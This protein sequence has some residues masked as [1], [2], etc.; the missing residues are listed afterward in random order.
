MCK[1]GMLAVH[2]VGII[3]PD[4]FSYLDGVPDAWEHEIPGMR[5]NSQN[6]SS[7]SFGEAFN[8]SRGSAASRDE[9]FY[10]VLGGA[11][12][13]GTVTRSK[14][15]QALPSSSYRAGTIP[16]AAEEDK[17]WSHNSQNWNK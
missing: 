3:H 10:C 12:R 1:R 4:T 5:A 9:E 2:Q 16:A 13:F 6:D 14:G 8:V 17:D 7:D 11:F 15:G